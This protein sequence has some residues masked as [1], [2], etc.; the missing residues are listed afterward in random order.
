M[1]VP[2]R[3]KIVIS[4]GMC[5]PRLSVRA[6]AIHHQRKDGVPNGATR[7]ANSTE[8]AANFDS[9][10]R[11]RTG[12]VEIV[13]PLR[14][15]RRFESVSLQRGVHCE[16]SVSQRRHTALLPVNALFSAD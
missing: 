7:E 6:V 2:A 9:G 14:G 12:R 15:D 3:S 1:A 13:V 8:A 11:V 4:A 5:C 16:P 10:S